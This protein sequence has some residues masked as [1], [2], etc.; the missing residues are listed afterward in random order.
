VVLELTSTFQC[1]EGSCGPILTRLTQKGFAHWRVSFVL[2]R[3]KFGEGTDSSIT[4]KMVRIRA[5]PQRSRGV[6]PEGL[7]ENLET[8]LSI[9]LSQVDSGENPIFTTSLQARLLI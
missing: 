1:A 2:E 7:V 6:D 3:G 9:T 8:K 4:Q 5:G